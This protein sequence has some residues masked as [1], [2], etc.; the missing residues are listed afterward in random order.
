[1]ID[2]GD[3]VRLPV[4]RLLHTASFGLLQSIR[5]GWPWR[6]D[7]WRHAILV[8][9]PGHHGWFAVVAVEFEPWELPDLEEASDGLVS[10]RIVLSLIK[11]LLE[12]G[13]CIYMDNF[14]SSPA[15]FR[16]LSE[17]QTD[18]VG[19]VQVSRKNMPQELKKPIAKG[20]IVARF[21]HDMMALKWR[22]KR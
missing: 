13:Y 8:M 20:T 11:E 14:Y 4:A 22:D 16:Q 5:E 10:S 19:T 2:C 6:D 12:K 7:E 21:M 17:Q 3:V 18:A 9:R 15:L 1:M